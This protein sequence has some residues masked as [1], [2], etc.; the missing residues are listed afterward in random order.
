[1]LLSD[2]ET[3]PKVKLSV[4]KQ[5]I[6]EE[7]SN[8]VI[9]VERFL[10][11]GLWY[12]RGEDTVGHWEWSCESLESLAVL[13]ALMPLKMPVQEQWQRNGFGENKSEP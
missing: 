6:S 11:D 13:A 4:L 10:W 8:N 1:M 7:I 3:R 12:C 9:L 2:L 5:S